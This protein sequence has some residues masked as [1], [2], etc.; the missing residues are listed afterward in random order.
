[1]KNE[2]DINQCSNINNPLIIPKNHGS[3]EINGNV[4][5]ENLEITIPD[6][7]SFIDSIHLSQTKTDRGMNK[8]FIHGC[9]N[10][11]QLCCVIL[12]GVFRLAWT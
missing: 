8:D 4:Q 2:C 7:N 5:T 9:N 12:L 11:G 1:M 6:N 3:N 10:L